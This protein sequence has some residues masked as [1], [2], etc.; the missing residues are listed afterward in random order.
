MEKY[1][2]RVGEYYDQDAAAFEERYWAN[3]TL[4]RTRM[5]FR[6]EVKKEAYKKVLEIGIGPGLDLA[7]FAQWNREAS[8]YGFDVSS[9]MVRLYVFKPIWTIR[10]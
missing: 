1:Y 2:E 7:H 6:A 9:E 5:H 10:A 8:L 3:Q 4:Q